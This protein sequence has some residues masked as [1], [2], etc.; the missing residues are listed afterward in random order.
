M[1]I[2]LV[3]DGVEGR[4]QHVDHAREDVE[5]RDEGATF[6]SRDAEGET[7]YFFIVGYPGEDLEVWICGTGYSWGISVLVL[8]EH[9]YERTNKELLRPLKI[10]RRGSF[11]VA[12]GLERR[13]DLAAQ[14]SL[15]H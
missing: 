15:A 14:G 5:T 12:G 9:G 8:S 6:Q 1:L 4:A 7:A 3:P 11:P 2:D 13:P 10:R